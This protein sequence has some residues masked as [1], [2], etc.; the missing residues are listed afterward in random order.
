MSRIPALA[1]SLLFCLL[2]LVPS[3][4]AQEED[5]GAYNV[6][7]GLSYVKDTIPDRLIPGRSYPV[8]ITFKNTGL[9]S[10]ERKRRPS[11]LRMMAM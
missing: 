1:L 3:V 10:W 11:S 5:T 7:F 8:L 4:L 2:I 9:V 6:G